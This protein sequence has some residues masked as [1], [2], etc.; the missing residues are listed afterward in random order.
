MPE[1]RVLWEIDL[2]AG[3]PCDAARLARE[4]R[5]DFDSSATVFTVTG[6]DDNIA[7][8]VAP[9]VTDSSRW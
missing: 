7:H 8:T 4:A 2:T 3:T 9:A 5:L 6:S 1:F